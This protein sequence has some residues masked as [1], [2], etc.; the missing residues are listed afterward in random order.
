MA[1]LGRRKEEAIKPEGVHVS[2]LQL[3]SS[4]YHGISECR[5][6]ALRGSPIATAASCQHGLL[7]EVNQTP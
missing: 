7:R 2:L 5:C 4:S 1:N 3:S 6:Q